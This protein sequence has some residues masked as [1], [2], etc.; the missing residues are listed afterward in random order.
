MILVD[1]LAVIILILGF[2]GGLKEGAVKHFFNLI[3]LIVAILVAGL[4]YHLI[5]I[6]LSFLPGT[7]WENFVGFFIALALVSV[8]LHFIVLLPRKIVQ[9]VWKR[10]ALFRLLGG[11]LSIV[12][13][14]IG[15]VVFALAVGAYPIFGW[16]ER[17]VTNSSVLTWLVE[18]LSFVQAMLPEAFRNAATLVVTGSLM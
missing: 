1:I 10:G 2:L 15:V 17:A 7:N 8:I 16:L 3:V 11:A 14:S 12:S 9:K 6:I 5:A 13:A 18:H 4:Y